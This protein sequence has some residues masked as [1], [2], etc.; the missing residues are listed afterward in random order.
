MSRKSII[1]ALLVLGCVSLSAGDYERMVE[2]NLW[3]SSSNAAA[4]RQE[5]GSASVATLY[6]TYTGGGFHAYSDAS[7]LFEAGAF[8]SGISQ[9]DRL[10]MKGSF[11]FLQRNGKDMFGS[12]LLHP[13]RY[14]VDVMEF[15]P[16]EKKLQTYS[17]D[18]ALSV[19]MGP[20]W[21]IGAGVEFSSS[22]Y[23][24][25]KD[26]RYVD[27]V[28]DLRFSPSLIYHNGPFAL[29]ANLIVEKN[30]ENPV[31]EQIGT[32]VSSYDAFI[33]KGLWFGVKRQWDGSGLH[34]KESGVSGFPVSESGYGLGLQASYGNAF[35]GAEFVSTSG[36][37]GEKRNIWFRFPGWKA[38]FNAGW[39]LSGLSGLHVLKAD[40]GLRRLTNNETILEKVSEGGVTTTVEYG[41]NTVMQSLGGT[42]DL[43]YAFINQRYEFRARLGGRESSSLSSVIYPYLCYRRTFGALIDLEGVAYLGKF[44]LMGRFHS[45]GGWY[46]ESGREASAN[47]GSTDSPFRLEEYNERALEYELCP[48][49]APALELRYELA[50][51]LSLAV[52]AEAV[53]AFGVKMTESP[54][55]YS[56]GL[57]MVYE[58]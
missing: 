5:T 11:S 31:A 47:S 1:S 39:K 12:M 38:E 29:G 46:R 7:S 20:Y 13:E 55:R 23:S 10:S 27:Y 8:A 24:K 51:G 3:Y 18:G 42:L 21:R 28:L 25:F 52:N 43:S 49:F 33:N 17:F 50:K 58:F 6:G 16:G 15:T 57:G 14:P 26:L 19:D 44:R 54:L 56:A 22:N 9:G 4:I 2:R 36:K 41:S 53:C 40:L 35:L 32:T 48:K 37:A 45:F 30:S 34:L